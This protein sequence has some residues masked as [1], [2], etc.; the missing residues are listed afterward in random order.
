MNGLT[1]FFLILDPNARGNAKAATITVL[2]DEDDRVFFYENMKYLRVIIDNAAS[3]VQVAKTSE[4][5][6]TIMKELKEELNA[7]VSGPSPFILDDNKD[8]V[9]KNLVFGSSIKILNI[10]GRLV[11]TLSRDDGTVEGGRAI[12]DGKDQSN[13]KVSSGVYIYLIYNEEGIT[14]S[15]KIAVINP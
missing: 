9:I 2:I 7:V 5:N 12:W 13:A 10:N 3:K 14:A 1:Y 15:G 4:E 11:R 6:E 8:F